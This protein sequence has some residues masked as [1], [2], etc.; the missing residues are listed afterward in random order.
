MERYTLAQEDLSCGCLLESHFQN[1][2][3]TKRYNVAQIVFLLI[4]ELAIVLFA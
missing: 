2:V 3:A 1:V 4:P